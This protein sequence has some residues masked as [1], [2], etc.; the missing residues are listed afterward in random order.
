MKRCTCGCKR[1]LF[2]ARN[3]TRDETKK[4]AAKLQERRIEMQRLDRL[5]GKKRE[6]KEPLGRLA[7]RMEKART[8]LDLS[9]R[10]VRQ[11]GER[12]K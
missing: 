6:H 9:E 12:T 11:L 4:H 2:V 10:S 1:A 7:G 3:V 5:A 8:D